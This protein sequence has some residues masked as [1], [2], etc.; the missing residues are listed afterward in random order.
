MKKSFLLAV[1][2]MAAAVG[3]ALADG[4]PSG[5]K[6]SQLG[7]G[8]MRVEA[9]TAGMAVRGKGFGASSLIVGLS[10]ATPL[11]GVASAAQTQNIV[12][13]HAPSVVGSVVFGGTGFGAPAA[14]TGSFPNFGGYV[15]I[16]FA[17]SV[18]DVSGVGQAAATGF[19]FGFGSR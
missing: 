13:G 2:L 16:P 19:L 17:V 10:A 1:V 7:L 6:L 12:Y 15:S 18:S 11:G 14:G 3:P 9:D 8:S 4:I 5:A